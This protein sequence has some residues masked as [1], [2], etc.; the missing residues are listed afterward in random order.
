MKDINPVVLLTA[1]IFSWVWSIGLA[2]FN[3]VVFIMYFNNELSSQILTISGILNIIDLIFFSRG[4]GCLPVIFLFLGSLI[5]IKDIWKSLCFALI[6][7]NIFS[8]TFGII[9]LIFNLII[10]AKSTNV[11]NDNYTNRDYLNDSYFNDNNLNSN[12]ESSNHEYDEDLE[13]MD[14]NDEEIK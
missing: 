5:A 14:S 2:I 10:S 13:D 12:V 9:L 4:K 11:V 1:T 7:E 3:V 8:L 6:I